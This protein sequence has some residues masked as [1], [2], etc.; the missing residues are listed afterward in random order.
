MHFDYLGFEP[1][2]LPSPS[3]TYAAMKIEQKIAVYKEKLGL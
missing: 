3:A 1:I 2:Y